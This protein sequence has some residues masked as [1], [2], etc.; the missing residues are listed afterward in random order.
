[1]KKFIHLLLAVFVV[2]P[3][4][5][6][7]TS[8]G[9][10]ADSGTGGAIPATKNVLW[11]YFPDK[12]VKNPTQNTN[13][14]VMSNQYEDFAAQDLE[15]NTSGIN[16]ASLNV[17]SYVPQPADFS[18]YDAVLLFE[19]GIFNNTID[20]GN[21]I[22][23]YQQGGGGVVLATFVDQDWSNNTKYG[24]RPGWGNLE[25]VSPLI[26]DTQGCEY[27]ADNMGTILDPGHP[28]MNGVNSLYADSYRGGTQLSP[29]GTA[30]ALWSTPN[31]LG[32]N[33]P[34]V[35][36]YT[37]VTGGRTAAISVMP[38]YGNFGG[39]SG[40][41]YRLFQNAL[42]WV[43]GGNDSNVV[44]PLHQESNLIMTSS[45]YSNFS[46]LAY[47]NAMK[48]NHS[49]VDLALSRYGTRTASKV[50]AGKEVHAICDG[51][52]EFTHSDGGLY[53]FMK[54]HHP[55]CNGQDIMAYYGHISP[56]EVS[57][58]VIKDDPVGTIKDWANNS[59]VHLTLDTKTNRDL[60]SIKYEICSFTLD[61]ATNTVT[62][63]TNCGGT[64]LTR[65]KIKLKIGWGQVKTLAY[66]DNQGHLHNTSNFYINENA[67]RQLGF[68]DFFDL[69]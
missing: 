61:A 12:D 49:G 6:A 21:A 42:Q 38:H 14:L 44:P 55:D 45:D 13:V 66:R 58:E 47:Y 24:P 56:Y 1:M 2:C 43:A 33:D 25:S 29:D 51:T 68:I 30:L 60:K 62:S 65:G 8:P 46:T 35:A 69:Y 39:F 10:G 18:G 40:D 20:V 64:S 4:S 26:S 3:V 37:P 48:I 52:V 36:I 27:N 54:V 63:L 59:H 9:N 57:T 41:Y 7:F 23:N 53:S 15:A 22:Y 50:S 28:I 19:D 31:F 67:M 5:Y 32:T 17:S 34:I 16:F 11:H